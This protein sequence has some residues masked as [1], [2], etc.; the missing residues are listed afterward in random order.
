MASNMSVDISKMTHNDICK[1]ATE[2]TN[3]LPPHKRTQQIFN[4]NVSGLYKLAYYTNHY[5]GQRVNSGKTHASDLLEN[6]MP[7]NKTQSVSNTPINHTRIV[8]NYMPSKKTQNASNDM[9]VFSL[10]TKFKWLI[11]LEKV[12][13]YLDDR[14]TRRQ[15]DEKD[16]KMMNEWIITQ[17]KYY[18]DRLQIMADSEI[19]V[20]WYEFVTSDKYKRFFVRSK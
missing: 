6:D 7:S 9:P 20:A 13:V 8:S 2:M 16:V 18:K 3:R 11:M 15:N 5:A 1:L 10:S 14:K 19:R 17:I 4:E 12:K